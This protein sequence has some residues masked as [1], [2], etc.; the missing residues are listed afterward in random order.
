MCG[1]TLSCW[2]MCLFLLMKGTTCGV[3][4]WSTYRWPLKCPSITWKSVCVWGGGGHDLQW[5][6][7]LQYKKQKMVASARRRCRS[8]DDAHG[9]HTLYQ[10]WITYAPFSISYQIAKTKKQGGHGLLKSKYRELLKLSANQRAFWKEDTLG[11]TVIY[12]INVYLEG[13]RYS[14][15]SKSM[16]KD[17]C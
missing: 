3:R 12:D 10:S 17:F 13:W 7:L 1:L 5:N 6:L 9:G 14:G 15:T 11:F 4:I 8:V 2:K 16:H